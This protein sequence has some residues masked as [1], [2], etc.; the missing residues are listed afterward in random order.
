MGIIFKPLRSIMSSTWIPQFFK[1]FAWAIVKYLKIKAP[2]KF[3]FELPGGKE[4]RLDGGESHFQVW[5]WWGIR[6]HEYDT[7]KIVLPIADKLETVWDVGAYYGQYS[8]MLAKQNPKLKVLAFEP[9]PETRKRF[10]EQIKLNHLANIEVVPL[11]VSN[12]AGRLEFYNIKHNPS[13]SSL[14]T[15]RSSN[16][17]VI[18]VDVKSLDEVAHERSVSKIDLIKIDVEHHELNVLQGMKSILHNARPLIVMEILTA[19]P[20]KEA[21]DILVPANY[22]FFF[23]TYDG[24]TRME[25]LKRPAHEPKWRFKQRNPFYN[26]LLCPV[27]KQHLIESFI[28]P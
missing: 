16:A 24:L 23:I 8:L 27:E 7:L 5:Y 10:E 11:A 13:N 25:G 3:S 26:F 21:E 28:I 17:E 12:Q 4:L 6:A 15:K 2:E 14:S 22:V 20:S 18:L 9:N 1:Y 19:F